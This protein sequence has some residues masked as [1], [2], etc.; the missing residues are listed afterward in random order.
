VM[1]SPTVNEKYMV[2]LL[3]AW[4]ETIGMPTESLPLQSTWKD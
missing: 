1:T 2:C 4:T 3:Q